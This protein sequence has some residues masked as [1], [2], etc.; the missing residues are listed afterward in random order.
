MRE[1]GQQPGKS[2]S[3][4]EDLFKMWVCLGH[5]VHTKHILARSEER[6]RKHLAGSVQKSPSFGVESPE[7]VWGCVHMCTL[8]IQRQSQHSLQYTVG[9]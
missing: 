2:P 5:L 1:L 3:S 7:V 8:P 4:L 9:G 6:I